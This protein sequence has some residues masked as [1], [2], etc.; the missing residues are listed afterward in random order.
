M[1]T[2][3]TWYHLTKRRTKDNKP[4][5]Y[6]DVCVGKEGLRVLATA[7]CKD[8]HLII[9]EDTMANTPSFDNFITACLPGRLSTIYT[10]AQDIYVQSTPQVPMEFWKDLPTKEVNSISII[11]RKP[12]QSFLF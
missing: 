7:K 4:K 1:T 10:Q 9:Y 12:C 11:D 8:V 5:V 6:G 3:S 2:S